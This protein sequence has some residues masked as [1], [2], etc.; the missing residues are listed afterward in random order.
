MPDLEP[1]DLIL[2][3]KNIGFLIRACI[4]NPI[5]LKLSLFIVNQ[6]PT[7]GLAIA[8]GCFEFE[9]ETH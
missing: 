3:K 1:I 8:P 7:T 2:F 5:K 6:R 4:A 9:F